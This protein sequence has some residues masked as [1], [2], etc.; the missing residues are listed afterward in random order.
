MQKLEAI[1]ETGFKFHR[2]QLEIE[3]RDNRTR[4]Q[5]ASQ[6]IEGCNR[7]KSVLVVRESLS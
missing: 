4:Q 7:L 1:V 6:V 5:Y 2:S 3:V